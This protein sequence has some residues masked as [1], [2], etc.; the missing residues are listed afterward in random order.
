MQVRFSVPGE[1]KGKGRPRFSNAGK[2][3]KT[4]TPHDTVV[5][6]NLVRLSYTQA[7]PKVKLTGA[8]RAEIRAYF[9]IP[10]SVSKKKREAMIAG[11]VRYTKKIDADNLAKAVLDA[12]NNVA[13][14]D[15]KQIVELFVSKD[16]SE[17]PQVIVVLTEIEGG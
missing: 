11:K 14:D 17:E 5:Y 15:D 7:H 13:Y 1:P 6:E 3:V 4:Y 12:L 16:Y 8:L 10:A 9:P 2:Y